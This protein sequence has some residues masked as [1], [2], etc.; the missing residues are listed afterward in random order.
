MTRARWQPWA[1]SAGAI[2]LLV[3][4]RFAYRYLDVLSNGIHG[5][6][7]HVF[8]DELTAAIGAGLLMIPLL[9]YARAVRRPGTGIGALVLRHAPVL[10][11][12]SVLHTT[13]N[14]LFRLAAWSL[15]G[16]GHYDYGI[17]PIRY[18]MEFP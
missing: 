18:A 9:F 17:L 10:P 12:F 1:I 6:P 3:L 14:Y 2:L 4:D 8:L 7:L 11:L 15:L 13:L 5:M 16:L